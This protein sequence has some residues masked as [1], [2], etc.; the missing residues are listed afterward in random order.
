MA[1][2]RNAPRRAAVAQSPA[3]TRGGSLGRVW[4]R[5]RERKGEESAAASDGF[6]NK[7]L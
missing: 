6:V 3:W 7:I 1:A 4:R 2:V 5:A